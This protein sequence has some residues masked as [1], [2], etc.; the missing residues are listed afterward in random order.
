MAYQIIRADNLAGCISKSKDCDFENDDQP[1]YVKLLRRIATEQFSSNPK[2]LYLDSARAFL[3]TYEKKIPDARQDMAW[4]RYEA[5]A[6]FNILAQELE[7]KANAQE[8]ETV[9]SYYRTDA[10]SCKYYAENL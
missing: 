6:I 10:K 9:A 8:N 3:L 1:D 2:T 4:E 5:V 7:D